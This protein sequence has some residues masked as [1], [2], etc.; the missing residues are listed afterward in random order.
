MSHP[1][2]DRLDGEYVLPLRWDDDAG[3]GELTDYLA[4]LRRWVDVTV[5]DGSAPPL[6][7]GHHV[8]WPF[9]RHIPPAVAGR[10]GKAR[11]AVTGIRCSRH[12]KIVIA[13]DDVRYGRQQLTT[14]L[15]RLDAADAVRPQNVFVPAP[16]HARWDTGR[17]L[18]NRGLGGDFSGTVA[19]RRGALPEAGYDTDVLFEN[20]E[21][22]RTVRAH[23]GR[24]DVASD[25][26]VARR[27]PELAKFF[28]QRVRQAY[29]D[30]AQPG[31]LAREL[32]LL[33]LMVALLRARNVWGL[34]VLAAVV[35][36]VAAIGRAR[37][38]G[39]RHFR[40][41]DCLWAV[42]WAMERAVTVWIAVAL[43]LRGGVRYRDGRI[44]RAATPLRTLR[45]AT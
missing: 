39:R 24:V 31:R 19:V 7:E 14:V 45:R 8:T 44:L 28:E 41:T 4:R 1:E 25:V 11:G 6:F 9:V 35:V 43:R 5:V 32:A 33:P 17:S 34:A 27:P 23:G 20:L 21:L 42:P 16:W 40:A 22:E 3:L 12:E 29:D 15:D 37:A 13:D 10:N 36:A 18:L 38:G 30:L 2:H 26:Y